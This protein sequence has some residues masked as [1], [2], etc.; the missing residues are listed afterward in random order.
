MQARVLFS[1]H[2]IILYY[3]SKLA[4]W[5]TGTLWSP[6]VG[7]LNDQLYCVEMLEQILTNLK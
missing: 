1:V 2:L 6:T 4:S 3:Q 7:G 5:Q